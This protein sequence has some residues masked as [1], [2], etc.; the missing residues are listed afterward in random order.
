MKDNPVQKQSDRLSTQDLMR[1]LRELEVGQSELELQNIELRKLTRE[2]KASEERYVDLYKHSPVGYFTLT[3][4]SI[5]KEANFSSCSMFNVS[6]EEFI[7]K[8]FTDYIIP[9]DQAIYYLKCKQLIASGLPQSFEVR[10]LVNGRSEIWVKMMLTSRQEESGAQV[11]LATLSDITDLKTAERELLRSKND[12]FKTIF[13]NVTDG[14][15]LADKE[16]MKFYMG[17]NA[18]CRMLGYSPREIKSLKVSDIHPEK[19]LPHV[20]AQFKRQVKGEIKL[21]PDMPVKRKDGSVFYADINTAN[22]TIDS[23]TFLLGIFHDTTDRKMATDALI[24]SEKRFMDVVFAS[25]DAILLIDGTT[26]VEC[27]EATARMLKYNSRAEF[28]LSHP[29]KLSP[30]LQPDGRDSFEK[31]NEMIQTAF[32]KGFHRFIWMHRRADGEDFPVEVSLT[33]IVMHGKN[34]LHC[35]WRDVSEI[36]RIQEEKEK[37][38][39]EVIDLYENAPC[40]YHSLDKDGLFVRINNTELSWLGYTREELVGKKK[41]TDIITSQGQELF[42]N[43]F[44]E[45]KRRGFARDLEF[46]VIRKDGETITLMLN[47]DA[48]KDSSGNFIMSRSTMID[49][50]QYKKSQKERM[51]LEK[52][53]YQTQRV[54]AIGSLASEITHD[55]NNILA[56]ILGYTNLFLS[57]YA[58]NDKNK[59]YVE[60]IKGVG[61]KGLKIVKQILSFG[62]PREK[63]FEELD[64]VPIVNDILGLFSSSLK[65]IVAVSVCVIPAQPPRIIGDAVQME[66]LLLNLISNAMDAM[67][68]KFGKLEITIDEV[69]IASDRAIKLRVMSGSYLKLSV[70]DT[71]HGMSSEVKQKLFE[72]FFSTKSSKGTGLGLSIVQRIVKDHNGVIRIESEVGVGTT[73]S[74]LFPIAPKKQNS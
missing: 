13:D 45:F 38:S 6:F 15:V 26:F 35:L 22:I 68:G 73:V 39:A 63:I 61:E 37:V 60:A 70:Q 5:V 69:L 36:Q 31:A 51:N 17:N 71:G 74:I 23:K 10:L 54:D 1:L 49:I 19:D 2:L 18:I 53:L 58:Q 21:A 72:P 33:P 4:E 34:I 9:E 7:N 64:I 47:A 30:P 24:E 46:E 62:K 8:S 14:I 59:E 44:P 28:L 40:G 16:T 27:N 3:K 66:Q 32:D 52:Q 20:S 57:D 42:K 43:E 65:H 50:T 29:S 25:G 67:D 55:F 48:I 12:E 56:S 41:F 11:F